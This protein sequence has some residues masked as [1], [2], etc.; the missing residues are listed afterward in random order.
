MAFVV[1]MN[2]LIMKTYAVSAEEFAGH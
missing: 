1:A 2:F